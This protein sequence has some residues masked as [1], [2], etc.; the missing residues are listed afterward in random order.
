MNHS[1]CGYEAERRP[2]AERTARSLA[3]G[4][5]VLWSRKVALLSGRR[6]RMLKKK[7]S[8][9]TPATIA[10]GIDVEAG[11]SRS[12]ATSSARP[13]NNA[14]ARTKMIVRRLLAMLPHYPA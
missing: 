4:P 10:S 2:V 14:A 9:I 1:R 3:P 13:Q 6:A 11:A 8:V 5:H 7:A 12:T